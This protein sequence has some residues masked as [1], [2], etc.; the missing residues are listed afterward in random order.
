MSYTR[1]KFIEKSAGG[2]I[3]LSALPFVFNSCSTEKENSKT[4]FVHHVYFWLHDPSNPEVRENF[5][6]GLEELV[7]I[8]TIKVSHLGIPADTARPVIDSSY[9][10]SLLVIFDDKEGHDI[11]QEHPTHLKFI[12]D[13]EQYWSKVL[14]Y[15]SVNY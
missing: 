6:K 8:E 9:A 4:M 3:A 11:Y 2:A 12:K 15:D 14:V 1:R 5:Q 13:C 10:Y 7:T